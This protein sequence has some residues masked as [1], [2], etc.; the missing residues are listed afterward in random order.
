MYYYN[1]SFFQPLIQCVHVDFPGVKR[2]RLKSIIRFNLM[3]RIRM[4]GAIPLLRLHASYFPTQILY[5]LFVMRSIRSCRGDWHPCSVGPRKDIII[6]IIIIII[7]IVIY[8]LHAGY[9]QLCT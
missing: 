4:S 8:H 6:I 7:V 3:Q 1:L 9:V 5:F 2:L